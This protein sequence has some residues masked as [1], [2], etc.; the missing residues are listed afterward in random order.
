[1]RSRKFWLAIVGA[2]LPVLN[3]QFGIGLEPNEVM[4]AIGAIV[5]FIGGEAYVDG[6]R[7]SNGTA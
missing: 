1:M 7:A 6:Q 2:I 5:A 4:A 3:E